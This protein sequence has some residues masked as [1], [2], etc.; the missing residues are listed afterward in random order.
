[1]FA[2]KYHIICAII[3]VYKNEDSYKQTLKEDEG[4]KK[5]NDEYINAIKS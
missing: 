5:L 4:N 1:M 3:K 2:I